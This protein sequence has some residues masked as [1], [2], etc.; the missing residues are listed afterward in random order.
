MKARKDEEKKE[1]AKEWKS[2]GRWKNLS[3]KEWRVKYIRFWEERE[4]DNENTIIKKTSEI[5][6]ITEGEFLL[7]QSK[8]TKEIIKESGIVIHENN[9][10]K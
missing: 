6:G 3:N 1:I 8:K 9:N 4:R 10:R 2:E 5:C 7:I